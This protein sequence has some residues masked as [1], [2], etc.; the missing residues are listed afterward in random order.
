MSESNPSSPHSD[1][2]REAQAVWRVC[3]V[4]RG[5]CKNCPP[6]EMIDGDE[7]RRGCYHQAVECINTVETGNPWRKTG[8]VKAPWVAHARN[9]LA[10]C[11]RCGERH[12]EHDWNGA[13]DFPCGDGG[14][15]FAAP[16]ENGRSDRSEAVGVSPPLRTATAAR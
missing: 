7:C 3:R 10:R 15:S 8:R 11:A 13:D 12:I 2:G 9:P 1:E 16:Q 5:D 6:R 14:G 4:I